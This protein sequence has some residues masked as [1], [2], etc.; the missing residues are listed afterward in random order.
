MRKMTWRACCSKPYPA[1]NSLALSVESDRSSHVP[2]ATRYQPT[3]TGSANAQNPSST[4]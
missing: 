1:P 3:A 4:I 2:S